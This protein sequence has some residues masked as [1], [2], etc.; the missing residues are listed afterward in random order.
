MWALSFLF[1]TIYDFIVSKNVSFNLCRCY[2]SLVGITELVWRKFTYCVFRIGLERYGLLSCYIRAN[3]TYTFSSNPII[4]SHEHSCHPLYSNPRTPITKSIGLL[5]QC[6]FSYYVFR[7][8]GI[9]LYSLM[10]IK[11]RYIIL[12]SGLLVYYI[13]Y[14]FRYRYRYI[15]V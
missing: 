10:I 13:I 8:M 3:E 14:T 5:I 6:S 9:T 4:N 2:T 1:K 12:I 7:I 15:E 11:C